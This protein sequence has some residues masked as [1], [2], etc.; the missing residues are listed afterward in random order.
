MC[1]C[2]LRYDKLCVDFFTICVGNAGNEPYH[3]LHTQED[4]FAER[5]RH[6][7]K[8]AFTAATDA[9]QVVYIMSESDIRAALIALLHWCME[10]LS[11]DRPKMFIVMNRLAEIRDGIALTESREELQ[12][13]YCQ[14][15]RAA[16]SGDA[17]PA[18]VCASVCVRI[19]CDSV[20]VCV[21]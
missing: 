8:D 7:A 19:M 14:D 18:P 2:L 17:V 11:D 9:R 1:A 3:W 20:P 15:L 5:M 6:P 10:H 21:C 12:D 16:A 4:V 13:R